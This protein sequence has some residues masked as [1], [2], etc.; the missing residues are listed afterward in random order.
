MVVAVIVVVVVLAAG[1]VVLSH[2][3]DSPGKECYPG[4]GFE[5]ETPLEQ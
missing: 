1:F 5:C 4:A 2:V 3:Q